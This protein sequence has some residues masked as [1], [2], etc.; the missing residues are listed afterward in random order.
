MSKRSVHRFLGYLTAQHQ[1]MIGGGRRS[2]V[3]YRPELI[4]AYGYDTKYAS[5]AL[6]LAYQG[7]EIASKGTLTL[8][9]PDAQRE[10]VLRVKR[11]E[12]SRENVSSQI[13]MVQHEI[14]HQLTRS[15]LP[16]QPDWE[17]IGAF[18]VQAH[19]D[20]WRAQR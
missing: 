15:I 17:N 13:L 4:E 1:R 16:E 10:D 2:A 11:G 5:H 7:L 6:R 9:L 14:E 8:P 19:L 12:V 3:P 20:H 18:S